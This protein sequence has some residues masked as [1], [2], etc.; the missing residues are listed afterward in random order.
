MAFWFF[1][2]YLFLFLFRPYEF[3]PDAAQMFATFQVMPLTLA[4]SAALCL[5]QGLPAKIAAPII[6]APICMVS[7]AFSTVLTGWVGGGIAVF[8][9]YWILLIQLAVASLSIRSEKNLRSIFTLFCVMAVLMAINGMQQMDSGEGF[10]G[11]KILLENN[12]PRIRYAGV[13]GDPNDLGMYFLITLPM[14]YYLF[15]NSNNLFFKLLVLTGVGFVLYGIYLTNSRGTVVAL[16]GLLGLVL[17]LKR[18]FV[19]IAMGVI[20]VLALL[21]LGPSRVGEI[22]VGEES[23]WGRIQAW[24]EGIQILKTNPLFGVGLE[25]FTDRYRLVAHNSFV[26]VFSELGLVGYMFWLTMIYLCLRYTFRARIVLATDKKIDP[27]GTLFLS[28]SVF[29]MA[30]FFLT[31][32]FESMLFIMLGLCCAVYQFMP[33]LVITPELTS[34]KTFQHVGVLAIMSIF[35][36]AL[37]SKLA[38]LVR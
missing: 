26:Q 1:Y 25:G 15:S 22:E 36:I 30:A 19:G 14:S 27:A 5:A 20:A 23:A 9:T 11:V 10:S 29:L 3:S 17:L 31:R 35:G 13:L 28:F 7:F 32:S 33:K 37:I 18:N 34:T 2:F 8:Q 24:Y 38:H 12:V 6:L 4:I 21:A 16:A